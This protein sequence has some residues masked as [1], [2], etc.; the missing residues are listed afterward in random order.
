MLLDMLFDAPGL[1]AVVVVAVIG[2]IV[3]HELGHGLVALWEGDPTPRALGRITFDPRVHLGWISIL[4]VLAMGIGWGLMPVNPRNFRHRRYG[5]AIVA[6][7]GPAVNLLLAVA[8]ATVLGAMDADIQPGMS[9]TT[10][11]AAVFWHEVTTLNVLLFFFNMLPLPPLDGFT[12]A[13][14]IFDLGGLGEFLRRAQPLTL[15]VA[16]AVLRVDGSPVAAWI[17]MTVSGLGRIFGSR[18]LG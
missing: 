1:Y 11:W 15:I 7:A 17:G 10:R 6:F 18:F 13:D 5:H 9:E 12:V 2:S 14:G 16:I 8:G 4:L 3:L